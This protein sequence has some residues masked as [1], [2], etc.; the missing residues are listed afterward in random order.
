MNKSLK[1][2]VSKSHQT[3]QDSTALLIVAGAGM[4]ID[5]GLPDYRVPNG[6][7]NTW[8]PARELQMRYEDLST[9]QLFESNPSLAWGFQSYLTRLYHELEP[10]QGYHLLLKMGQKHLKTIIL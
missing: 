10:H 3:I 9:H 1:E 7:W 8:H 5:S 2:A 6:L 4:G